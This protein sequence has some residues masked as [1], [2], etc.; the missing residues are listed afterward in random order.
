MNSDLEYINLSYTLSPVSPACP[1]LPTPSVCSISSQTNGDISDVYQITLC[2]HVG[3]HIDGPQHMR[4]NKGPLSRWMRPE[5]LHCNDVDIL[6]IP[7][8]PGQLIT[9][10][11]L[12]QFEPAP[13][14]AQ[15][16]LIRTGAASLRDSDPETYR[17]H[18]PGLDASAANWICEHY[19]KL[20]CLGIDSISVASM[21]HI[22]DGIAAHH[23]FFDQNP[24]IL[25]IEDI[26]INVDSNRIKKV[27]VIPFWFEGLDSCHCMVIAELSA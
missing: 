3:S 12:E 2:N 4:P 1:G 21:D 14:T 5:G 17:L 10:N 22:D 25:L 27:S 16:L 15:L 24:P 7:S 6:D 23:V 11:I 18:N 9:G 26:H 20:R 19:P 8:S 13:S